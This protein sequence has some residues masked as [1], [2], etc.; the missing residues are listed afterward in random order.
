MLQNVHAELPFLLSSINLRLSR[1]RQQ[2]KIL[3]QPP[4][5]NTQNRQS[6]YHPRAAPPTNTERKVPEVIS[7]GLNL[8]LLFQE[9]LRPKLFWFLP[10][11]WVVGEPPCINQDFALGR[12]VVAAELGIVEVHVRD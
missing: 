11:F 9:P 12:D 7:I 5:S 4:Q 3:H 2:L 6:K 8:S 1:R 10:A